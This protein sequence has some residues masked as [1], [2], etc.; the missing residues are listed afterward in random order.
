MAQEWLFQRIK[1]SLFRNQNKSHQ[2]MLISYISGICILGIK[3][4]YRCQN[5]DCIK[6]WNPQNSQVHILV[7][8]AVYVI[9]ALLVTKKLFIIN[10]GQIWLVMLSA[11][12]CRYIVSAYI[13]VCCPW[14]KKHYHQAET[15]SLQIF[16]YVLRT[17]V[18]AS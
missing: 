6:S 14:S 8:S 3:C 11:C 10:C 4:C 9:S 17:D 12:V 13:C 2:V 16:S 1:L 7:I 5:I 15:S 18:A